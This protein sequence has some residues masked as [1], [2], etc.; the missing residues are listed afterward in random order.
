MLTGGGTL[1]S[2]AVVHRSQVESLQAD[3]PFA[4]GLV[5]LD[6]GPLVVAR[7]SDDLRTGDRVRVTFTTIGRRRLPTFV[8]STVSGFRRNER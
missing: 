4:I 7:T 6:E 1:R 5:K 8:A 3:T 2:W